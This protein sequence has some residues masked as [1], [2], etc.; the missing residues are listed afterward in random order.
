MEGIRFITDKQGRKTAVVIDLIKYGDL[1]ED[2]FDT[3]LASQR[4]K[5]PTETLEELRS[6]LQEQ[7]KLDDEV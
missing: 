4:E 7:G 3:W 6:R 1:W 2:F 5:E